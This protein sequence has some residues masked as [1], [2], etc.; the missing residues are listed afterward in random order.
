MTGRQCAHCAKT[1]ITLIVFT[2]DVMSVNRTPTDIKSMD[3]L[4]NVVLVDVFEVSGRWV[5]YFV[6]K[7]IDI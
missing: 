7:Y 6:S 4:E 5:L 2:S 3:L 1:T